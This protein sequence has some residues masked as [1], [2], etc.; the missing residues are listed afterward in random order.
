MTR[1]TRRLGV[2]ATFA[3]TLV[4]AG[5]GGSTGPLSDVSIGIRADL[6]GS[7]A[8]MV[9]VEVTGPDI[10]TPLVFNIPV[11]NGV[12]AGTIT[13]PT[14]SSRTITVRAF[15]TNTIETH[16]G[17]VTVTVLPG[18]NPSLSIVLAPLAGDVPI[19]ATLGRITITV[20]PPTPQVRGGATVALS[21]TITDA[22]GH[23]VA[24]TVN[25]ASR[26]PDIASVSTTGVVTGVAA[27]VATIVATFQGVAG[28]ATVSV[29]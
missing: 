1:S 2:A 22:D 12:A 4:L 10:S 27:G 14:G 7:T 19:S 8:A 15:D 5:C 9:V 23:T 21:A 20:S 24:G 16:R 3:A 18:S 11:E 25:W 29:Q 13:I 26:N 6:S 17:T 28:S